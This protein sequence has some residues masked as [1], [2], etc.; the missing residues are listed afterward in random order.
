[1]R[2]FR[3]RFFA[4]IDLGAGTLRQFA[5]PADEVGMQ[6]R[7]EDVL[8]PE[9]LLGGSFQ[10][11]INIALRIDDHAD[12]AGSEQV[13]RVGQAAEIKLFEVHHILQRAVVIPF[14]LSDF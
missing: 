12:S 7:L 3:S 14:P 11:N 10:V 8:D 5:V 4:D 1:M 6:V 13:R 2:K 9:V